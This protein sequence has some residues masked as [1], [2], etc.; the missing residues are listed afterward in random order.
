MFLFYY[1]Y[2]DDNPLE[3]CIFY[4]TNNTDRFLFFAKHFLVL[5]VLFDSFLA[6]V[7]VKCI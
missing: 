2:S 1:S 7:M 3:I 5:L 6:H 4:V